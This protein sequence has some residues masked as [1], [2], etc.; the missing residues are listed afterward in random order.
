VASTGD[1]RVRALVANQKLGAG[2][3][4]DF[5]GLVSYKDYALRVGREG[6]GRLSAGKI[7]D[8]EVAG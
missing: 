1:D 8:V 7:V 3:A 6:K 2:M 5:L 4:G